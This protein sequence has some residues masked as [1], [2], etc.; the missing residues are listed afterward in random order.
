MAAPHPKAPEWRAKCADDSITLEE[1]RVCVLWLRAERR[2]AEELT[3]IKKA[4]KGK[5]KAKEEEKEDDAG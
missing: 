2:E 5:R 4:A 3:K 1:Y